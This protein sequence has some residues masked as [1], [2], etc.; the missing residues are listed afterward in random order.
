MKEE[1]LPNWS[2]VDRL[3]HEPARL[4]IVSILAVVEKADFLYLQ[5]ETSLTKGNLSAHLSKLENAGY[6]QI[7]KTFKGKMPLTLVSLTEQG[8]TALD[9]YLSQMKHWLN[10]L[11]QHSQE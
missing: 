7:E 10:Q 11:D 4:A 2:A 9:R 3:L 5:H 1:A 8:R 6:I